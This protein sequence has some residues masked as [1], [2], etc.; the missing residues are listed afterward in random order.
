MKH[1]KEYNAVTSLEIGV[2]LDEEIID[3]FNTLVDDDGPRTV[4]YEGTVKD[5]DKVTPYLFTQHFL[6]R[7]V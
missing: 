4:F 1:E 6:I 5:G 7:R 3:H 2:D